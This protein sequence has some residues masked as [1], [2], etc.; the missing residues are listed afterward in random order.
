FLLALPALLG[1]GLLEVPDLPP[2][3]D[4]ATVIAATAVAALIGFLSIA[5]LLR[6][7]RTHDTRPFA[8]YCVVFSAAALA[9]AAFLD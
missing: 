5:F 4:T 8:Y 6:Y 7:L 9:Y 2:S 1:A 3:T